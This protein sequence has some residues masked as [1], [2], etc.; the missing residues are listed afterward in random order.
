MARAVRTVSGED[1]SK[2][3]SHPL[4]TLGQRWKDSGCELHALPPWFKTEFFREAC[5][6]GDVAALQWA[7]VFDTYRGTDTA[8]VNSQVSV[9]NWWRQS[10]LDLTHEKEMN[11]ASEASHVNVLQW[12][13]D[14]G[15]PLT[16]TD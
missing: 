6:K 9:L 11:R 3:L 7:V 1:Y 8:T 16:N 2:W 10:G 13:K 4:E 5:E 14:S 15:L 12:W